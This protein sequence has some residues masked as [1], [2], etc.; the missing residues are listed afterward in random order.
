MSDVRRARLTTRK[1]SASVSLLV[2]DKEHRPKSRFQVLKKSVKAVA[3]LWAQGNK[4]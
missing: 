4:E 2:N 3:T 1:Q